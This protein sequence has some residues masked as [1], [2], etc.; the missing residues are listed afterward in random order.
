MKPLRTLAVCLLVAALCQGCAQNPGKGNNHPEAKSQKISQAG[1]TERNQQHKSTPELLG[2]AE[3][4]VRKPHPMSLADLHQK[5]PAIY[6]LNGPRSKRQVALTFDDAPDAVFTPQ[7]L[8]AL[9]QAGVKA[10]FFVVGNRAEAHP[11]IM[12][13]I[14]REGHRVGNHSYSHA[15]LPKLTDLKFRSE[16][17]RTDQIIS[18]YTGSVPALFRPP[19]GNTNERQLLW[20]ASKGKKIVGWNVDSL[21]WKGLNADQV[22]SNVL[23]HVLPGSIILQHAAGGQGED[24]SGTVAAI[25]RIV[26]SLKSD[27]VEIVTVEDLLNLNKNAKENIRAGSKQ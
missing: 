23:S 22:S 17:T 7:V 19:Y 12:A 21:D 6:E 11:D 16:V 2:G 1:K 5:Y 25:P 10:T 8:D 18:N 4:K 15:N 13:R 27:G 24:L 14:V 9:K 20:L 26:K 3:G